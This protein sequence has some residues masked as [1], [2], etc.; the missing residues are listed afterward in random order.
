MATAADRILA[1]LPPTFAPL[2]RPTAISAI[3]D[4]FGGELSQAENAL[5]ALMF[6]HWV[7]FADTNANIPADL[8]SI[9]S[10]YGLAPRDDETIEEFRAHLKRYVRTFIEGTV[11]VRGVCR[12]VAEALG[13]VIADEYAQIDTWWNRPSGSLTSV[14][15]AGDD[16]ATLLFGVPAVDVR[17][18]AAGP[19]M[20]IGTV[21][22]S[23]PVDLRGRS[24]LRLAVDGATAATFDLASRIGDPGAASLNQIVTALEAIPGV[25]AASQEGR[26]IGRAHV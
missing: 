18:V 9:A 7:D 13:L 22:F 14:D 23:A 10:L 25:V 3:A 19:A 5:A 24:L 21:D 12:I 1:N 6:S 8:S 2:P 20:F 26:Q 15:P 17:G 11:T 16:A 4:A